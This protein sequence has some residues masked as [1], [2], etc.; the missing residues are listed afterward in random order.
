MV[1]YYLVLMGN[2]RVS[3]QPIFI[4]SILWCPTTNKGSALVQKATSFIFYFALNFESSFISERK[5]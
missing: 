1:L 2:L 5:R 3:H 4:K